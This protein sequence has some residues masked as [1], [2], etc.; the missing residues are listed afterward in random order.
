[1]KYFYFPPILCIFFQKAFVGL[2]PYALLCC[3][4]RALYDPIGVEY[5]SPGGV[6][7]GIGVP[8]KKRPC[9]GRIIIWAGGRRIPRWRGSTG[10]SW[11]HGVTRNAPRCGR[12]DSRAS[13]PSEVHRGHASGPRYGCRRAHLSRSVRPR[14]L[15][16]ASSG[17][18]GVHAHLARTRAAVVSRCR[19]TSRSSGTS[20]GRIWPRHKL[21]GFPR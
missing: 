1:M 14:T 9:G 11:P 16:P 7:L 19:R 21:S 17:C 3:P 13:D 5:I 8:N 20:I 12:G 10:S 4:Y 2:I 18:S 6:P 15:C